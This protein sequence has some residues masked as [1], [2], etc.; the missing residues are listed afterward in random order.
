MITM[1]ASNSCSLHMNMLYVYDAYA[2]FL[3]V[4]SMAEPANM[5][6][7]FIEH[8]VLLCLRMRSSCVY[9]TSHLSL[10][11][12]TSRLIVRALKISY[13]FSP[14]THVRKIGMITCNARG[15]NGVSL[16][17]LNFSIPSD[18]LAPARAFAQ[19]LVS[20]FYI[21]QRRTIN[22]LPTS[23]SLTRSLS[24]SLLPLY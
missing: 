16:P 24:P 19:T 21:P 18:V 2:L 13:C 10:F 12:F 8:D 20:L 4:R 11:V 14:S 15:A 17:R 3:R 7:V 23:I 5:L 9:P 1:T 6:C 22:H